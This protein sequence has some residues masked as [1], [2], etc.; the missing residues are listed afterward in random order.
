MIQPQVPV[1]FFSFIILSISLACSQAFPIS[2]S[3]SFASVGLH[4]GESSQRQQHQH[5]HQ[6]QSSTALFATQST[7]S[8]TGTTGA[9]H[10]TMFTKDK[11][12]SKEEL[13][14]ALDSL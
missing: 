11:E 14:D 12:Y 13:K 8:S 9:S 2:F 7:S 6:E 4:R 5:Q 1:V 10:N 3:S